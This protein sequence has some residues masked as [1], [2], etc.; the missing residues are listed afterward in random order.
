VDNN[1]KESRNI[2]KRSFVYSS[3]LSLIV[4]FLCMTVFV[5]NLGPIPALIYSPIAFL[6]SFVVCLFVEALLSRKPGFSRKKAYAIALLVISLIPTGIYLEDI[7]EENTQAVRMRRALPLTKEERFLLQST[8]L[9]FRVGV[10][11]RKYPPVAT[12]KLISDLQKTCLFGEVGELDRLENA[13]LIVTM[14]GYYRNVHNGLAVEIHIPGDSENG[15]YKSVYYKLDRFF[16]GETDENQYIDR[17][18][19]ELIEASQTLL[20]KSELI[21]TDLLA[22]TPDE[23]VGC[24]R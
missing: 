8:R 24:R 23:E 9:N 18:A 15:V 10:V 3:S 17:L 13:D 22:T 7:F 11:N 16:G 21:T 1:V 14:E 19:V 20:G 4:F 6:G 5:G 12:G 2:L